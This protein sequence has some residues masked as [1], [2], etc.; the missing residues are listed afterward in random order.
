MLFRS[1]GVWRSGDDGNGDGDSDNV[2]LDTACMEEARRC[3]AMR[4]LIDAVGTQRT[5]RPDAVAHATMAVRSKAYTNILKNIGAGRVTIDGIDHD[6]T[7]ENIRAYPSSAFPVFVIV[8]DRV[9]LRFRVSSSSGEVSVRIDVLPHVIIVEMHGA[10]KLLSLFSDSS[11]PSNDFI[12][13]VLSGSKNRMDRMIARTLR[14]DDDD[15]LSY[16]TAM[17]ILRRG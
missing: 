3:K 10:S 8:I 15:A 2:L 11:W 6:L 9:R 17:H 1:R 12:A 13:R 16:K 7:E 14:G 4:Q 5:V